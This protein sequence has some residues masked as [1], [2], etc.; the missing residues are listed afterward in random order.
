MI[1]FLLNQN[2]QEETNVSPNLTVLNYLREHVR[3]TGTKEGCGSGD[4][5]ACT[6]VLG[7]VVDGKLEYRSVNSCLTFVSALHGKQLITV[8]DLRTKNALHPVQ[9]AV[10]DFHGSQCGFCTPGFI[11]S[12]FALSKNHPNADKEETYEALAGN[13]CRCTGYRPIVEAAL[14]L[15]QETPIR[16]Q[17]A[18]YESDII[19]KLN[20]IGKP[21]LEYHADGKTAFTPTNSDE[22]AQTLLAHPNAKLL[23]GGTDLALEVTQFH[24]DIEKLIYLGRV[25][26]IK[27]V[28]ETDSHIDIGANVPFTDVYRALEPH[29]P[30]FG[31]LLQRFASLQIRNQGTIGGNIANASPI[32]DGPPLLIALGASIVLRRGDT[33]REIQLED[34]FKGYKVTELQ[35]SEFVQTIRVPKPQP[36]QTFKA[37]KIS[38]R[39]DDDISAVCGAFRLTFDGDIISDARIAF[40][41]MAAIPARA[42]HCEQA[43]VGQR[44]T[45]AT[46]QSAMTALGN[47]FSPISDFRASKEYRAETAANLLYRLFTELNYAADG[48]TIETRVIHYVP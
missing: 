5:G 13:L 8:E 6:V 9:Q 11:M 37:Y 29:Y 35:P 16:D 39:F 3:K 15:S 32:G 26:D 33:A 38:K 2:L 28:N 27:T 40:G 36:D 10:V 47:D 4:C 44:L 23:A 41:G 1:R 17:F 21:D 25:D 14:S 31:A 46:I 34:F 45:S 12:M 19:A 7:E 30:D 43:L 42:S 22:L 48:K 24:R 20:A 18:E